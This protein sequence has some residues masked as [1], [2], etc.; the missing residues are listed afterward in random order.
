MRHALD[1]RYT[2]LAYEVSCT[3]LL[4][5][6]QCLVSIVALLSLTYLKFASIAAHRATITQI[7]DPPLIR[8]FN[9]PLCFTSRNRN[10]RSPLAGRIAKVD[11]I[12]PLNYKPISLTSPNALHQN[13]RSVKSLSVPRPGCPCFCERSGFICMK[14]IGYRG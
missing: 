3:S 10:S 8:K 2:I 5:H 4:T 6:C 9:H 14:R 7:R 11:D 1:F 12:A 13:P